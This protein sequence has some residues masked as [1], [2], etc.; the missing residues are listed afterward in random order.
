[1]NEINTLVENNILNHAKVIN[2]LLLNNEFIY[3]SDW[4][5]TWENMSIEI[6]WN[7]GNNIEL[8]IKK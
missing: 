4:Y 8:I 7:I 1:M 2:K 6:L 3:N 5:N